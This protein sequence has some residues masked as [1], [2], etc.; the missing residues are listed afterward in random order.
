MLSSMGVEKSG[1]MSHWG[2]GI[3][4]AGHP[5]HKNKVELRPKKERMVTCALNFWQKKGEMNIFK[6]HAAEGH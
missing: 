3:A 6:M 2:Q 1:I 5:G 4:D